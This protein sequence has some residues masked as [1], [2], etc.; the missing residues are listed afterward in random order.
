MNYDRGL[1]E[2]AARVLHQSDTGRT[3]PPNSE[4]SPAEKALLATYLTRAEA[5]L[6]PQR[7]FDIAALVA[8]DQARQEAA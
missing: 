4:A 3:L 7:T 6:R 1:V 8:A 2:H 5:A